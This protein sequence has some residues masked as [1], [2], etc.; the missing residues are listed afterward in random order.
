MNKNEIVYFEIGRNKGI[1]VA[2]P[3]SFKNFIIEQYPVSGTYLME[4]DSEELN[5]WKIKIPE[6]NYKY[7]GRS[8]EL[9]AEFVEETLNVPF[10][11]YINML[12]ELDITV[13]YSDH[14]N[15]W[16][17]LLTVTS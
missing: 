17:V 12:N 13:N 1:F 16:A 2:I 9:S 7:I 8:N 14:S 4:A 6:G 10:K 15:F 3:Y 11:D 5:H